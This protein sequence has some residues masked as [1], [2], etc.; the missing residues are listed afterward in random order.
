MDN[1]NKIIL[2]L[3]RNSQL[4]LCDDCLSEKL[5]IKPRQQVNQNCNKLSN[6]KIIKRSS[7]KEICSICNN[8]KLVNWYLRN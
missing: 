5:K 1:S 2:L 8:R 3:K 6:D 4:K 7:T